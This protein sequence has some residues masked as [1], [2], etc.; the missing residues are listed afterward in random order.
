MYGLFVLEN[1]SNLRIRNSVA[2]RYERGPGRIDRPLD[3]SVAS[4]SRDVGWN[5]L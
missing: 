1:Q 3:V 2:S 5:I 4:R